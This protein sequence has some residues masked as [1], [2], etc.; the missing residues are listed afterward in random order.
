M[1]NE[2]KVDELLEAAKAKLADCYIS[3]GEYDPEDVFLG[4]CWM[5]TECGNSATDAEDV[6]HD[7]DCGAGRLARAIEAMEAD[8]E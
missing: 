1:S 2:R 5:C 3:Y 7:E 6:A 4:D 8:H